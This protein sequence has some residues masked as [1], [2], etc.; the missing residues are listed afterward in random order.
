MTASYLGSSRG[1]LQHSPAAVRFT[2]QVY[3][4]SFIFAHLF[5]SY[6]LF[7]IQEKL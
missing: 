1:L 4:T 6:G 5:C 7:I 2:V 3:Y